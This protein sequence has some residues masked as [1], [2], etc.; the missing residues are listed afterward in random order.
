MFWGSGLYSEF[1]VLHCGTEL[2][3]LQSCFVKANYA[4]MVCC[5]G[6][7]TADQKAP[8]HNLISL[9]FKSFSTL[10]SNPGFT[11]WTLTSNIN[12][13]AVWYLMFI[14]ARC[15]SLFFTV[16][17]FWHSLYPAAPHWAPVD[18]LRSLTTQVFPRWRS[19]FSLTDIPVLGNTVLKVHKAKPTTLVLAPRPISPFK[20]W[21]HPVKSHARAVI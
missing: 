10:R 13:I 6:L 14:R 16:E 4:R 18:L 2:L 9:S 7:R 21:V 11:I 19:C 17:C 15:G 3:F 12:W 8:G 5:W 1:S 20:H